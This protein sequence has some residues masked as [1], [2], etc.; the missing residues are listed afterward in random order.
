MYEIWPA[1]LAR[2]HRNIFNSLLSNFA[3]PL[4]ITIS[5]ANVRRYA[6]GGA[7]VATFFRPLSFKGAADFSRLVYRRPQTDANTSIV[8]NN[9]HARG[10]MILASSEAVALFP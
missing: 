8:R 5:S 6:P 2:F 3:K 4:S 10:M 7:K 9:S 1:E